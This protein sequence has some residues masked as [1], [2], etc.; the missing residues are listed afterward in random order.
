MFS[1]FS[2][3]YTWGSCVLLELPGTVSLAVEKRY[4]G[5]A[6]HMRRLVLLLPLCVLIS[7]CSLCSGRCRRWM[8]FRM[9]TAWFL[10]AKNNARMSEWMTAVNAHVHWLFT[11]RYN[12]PEDNY[13]SQG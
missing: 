3:D 2:F 11:K 7:A 8:G 10:Q 4:S 1:S 5:R 6:V 9:K 13:W 12:V